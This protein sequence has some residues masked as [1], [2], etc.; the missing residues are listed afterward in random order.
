MHENIL[1]KSML[2]VETTSKIAQ[3]DLADPNVITAAFNC[4]FEVDC[5]GTC[6]HWRGFGSSWGREITNTNLL[7]VAYTHF[8]LS[9]PAKGV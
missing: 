2:F 7:R 1:P 3:S 4:S 8:T 5:L 6:G 9:Q